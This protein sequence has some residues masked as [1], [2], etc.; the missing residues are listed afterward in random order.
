[1]RTS[2]QFGQVRIL[3][4][5]AMR[6]LGFSDFSEED[7]YFTVLG[8]A[9]QGG[10]SLAFRTLLIPDAYFGPHGWDVFWIEKNSILIEHC[11]ATQ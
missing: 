7:R 2:I 3:T 5:E 9:T 1:M 11:D 4:E 10:R 6:K 8:P